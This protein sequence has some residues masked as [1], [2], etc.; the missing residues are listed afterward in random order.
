V[1]KNFRKRKDTTLFLSPPFSQEIEKTRK[2]YINKHIKPHRE[3]K[4][5]VKSIEKERKMKIDAENGA[6]LLTYSIKMRIAVKGKE[7][8]IS[9]TISEQLLFNYDSDESIKQLATIEHEMYELEM[10]ADKW[11]N[12]IK[13]LFTGLEQIIENHGYKLI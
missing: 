7:L 6:V 12:D 9:K 2:I 8:E 10:K 11:I 5:E 4:M 13:E 1:K 3:E